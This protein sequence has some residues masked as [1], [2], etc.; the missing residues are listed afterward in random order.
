[1]LGTPRTIAT[2][3]KDIKF[4]N[5]FFERVQPNNT[6]IHTTSHPYVSIC[7]DEANYISC[8][9]TPIVYID[10]IVNGEEASLAWAGNLTAPFRPDLV[11]LSPSGRVYYPS[12]RAL[13][14]EG[15][16]AKVGARRRLKSAFDVG[17]LSLLKS[18]IIPMLDF[19]E[20]SASIRWR[21]DSFPIK[22]L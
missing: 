11:Q 19:D 20:S 21:G 6:G 9:D 1:M 16:L 14:T 13:D 12:P 4:L 3:L 22:T 8:D 2:C 5:F 18:T 15:L 17:P 10:L 7:A